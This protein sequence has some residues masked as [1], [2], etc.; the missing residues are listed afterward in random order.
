MEGFKSCLWLA[1]EQTLP[2]DTAA[3]PTAAV[4]GVGSGT[5]LTPAV[6]DGADNGRSEPAD[7]REEGKSDDGL[8]LGAKVLAAD[9]DAGPVEDV[10]ATAIEPL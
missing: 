1:S 6:P 2:L 8:L 3:V 9:P 5:P 7:G 4:G 10:A